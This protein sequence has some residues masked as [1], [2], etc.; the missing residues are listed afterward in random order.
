MSIITLLFSPIQQPGKISTH[1]GKKGTAHPRELCL[2]YIIF[3]VRPAIQIKS[4]KPTKP[5]PMPFSVPQPD[6]TLN[7]YVNNN[8]SVFPDSTA[9][10]NQK[11]A[12][13]TLVDRALINVFI[14]RSN[15][16]LGADRTNPNKLL[17]RSRLYNRILAGL[18]HTAVFRPHFPPNTKTANI[19]IASEPIHIIQLRL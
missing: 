14:F 4:C 2:D 9:V 19:I 16:Q 3:P 13:P 12:Q 8:T 7:P 11:K 15:L 18:S 1:N 6:R 10:Q 17:S 5:V